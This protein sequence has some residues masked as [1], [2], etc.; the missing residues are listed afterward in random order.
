M[1]TNQ[2]LEQFQPWLISVVRTGSSTLPWIS[3]PHDTDYI[4]FVQNKR[5]TK[6]LVELYK[7]KP[8]NECWMVREFELGKVRI[9]SY[10]Y[11]YLQPLFGNEFPTYDIFEHIN[12]YKKILV[13]SGLGTTFVP[14]HKFWY[15]ILT[16]IYLLDNGKYELTPEQEN[17]IR[18]CH[19]RQMT[20]EIYNFIQQRLQEYKQE[21]DN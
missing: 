13:E 20:K 5:N 11:H 21:L 19:S 14:E 9:Y 16:G 17:E 3:M 2:E 15:H 1:L 12:E 6:Q 8:K 10:E 7:L 4:C 18:L